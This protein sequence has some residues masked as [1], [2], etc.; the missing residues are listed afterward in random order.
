MSDPTLA[1]VGD[2][3]EFKTLLDG[4]PVSVKI[5]LPPM[6]VFHPMRILTPI[7]LNLTAT[8][9]E[10]KNYRPRNMDGSCSI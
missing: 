6:T 3:I 9:L 10:S 7:L 1:K 5:I 4:K 8:A 2:E